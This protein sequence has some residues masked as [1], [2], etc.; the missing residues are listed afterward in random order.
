MIE[1]VKL[2]I[3]DY[4]VYLMVGGAAFLLIVVHCTLKGSLTIEQ[5]EKTPSGVAV[6]L[7]L[8]LFLLLGML[9][10]PV[11]NLVFKIV[12]RWNDLGFKK[13]DDEIE[14]LEQ[15]AKLYVPKGVWAEMIFLF[16]KNWVLNNGDPSEF[17]AFLSKYG[18]YRSIA[19]LFF[20]NT[21]VSLALYWGWIGGIVGI[22]NI[23]FARLYA[24]R[25][26]VFYRHMS[27]TIYSQFIHG[28]AEVK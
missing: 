10:E 2:G 22:I 20:L 7:L 17:N 18:F 24:Y 23:L 12:T 16:A 15:E 9:I 4:F 3:W 25:S 8:F 6:L 27:L 19:F 11:A 21:F 1:K 26:S 28:H 14:K 5:I 13:W